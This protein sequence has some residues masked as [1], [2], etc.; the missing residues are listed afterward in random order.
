MREVLNWASLL[1]FNLRTHMEKDNK[2]SKKTLIS[3]ITIGGLGLTLGYV[4]KKNRE[5]TGV[6]KNQQLTIDGLMKEVKNLSYHLG[7]KT[8]INKKNMKN[9]NVNLG[10]NF[11]VILEDVEFGENISEER[12]NFL[13]WCTEIFLGEFIKSVENIFP[14]EKDTISMVVTPDML[15]N[16]DSNV[17]VTIDLDQRNAKIV[18]NFNEYFELKSLIITGAFIY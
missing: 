8:I 16:L 17:D 6:I 12:Q 1:F 13:V 11:E 2:I 3:I 10:D 15:E 4:L 5:L 18:Y 14:E 7:K 9:L